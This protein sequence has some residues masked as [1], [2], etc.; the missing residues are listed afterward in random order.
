MARCLTLVVGVLIGQWLAFSGL[1]SP[2]DLHTL[3]VAA[4]QRHDY[5]EAA[6]VWTLAVAAHPDNALFH[7]L[8]GTA[9]ARLGQR[10]SATDAYQLTLLLEPPERI[11]RLAQEALLNLG[12]A[13]V[14]GEG[15]ETA[16]PLES[17]RGVWVVTATLNG[18]RQARF[19]VDSGSSVTL[20]SPALAA[21]LGIHGATVR[22]G[23]EL[24]TL[25][26]RTSGGSST[27][28]SLRVGSAELREAPVVVLSLIHI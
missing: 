28:A 13:Q 16:V 20:V 24:Q 8:R 11:A 1:P 19:L 27:V 2:A 4:Y 21:A 7:Y 12:G 26:G 5:A 14:E 18:S 9:L 6:R 10:T 17:M 23:V 15:G 3:G 22:Q 25:A